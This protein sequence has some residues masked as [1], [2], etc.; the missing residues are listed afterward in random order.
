MPSRGLSFSLTHGE[1]LASRVGYS[2]MR[3]ASCSLWWDFSALLLLKNF[4]G[5]V[6]LREGHVKEILS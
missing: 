4:T 5:V 3:P 6:P 2:S 1:A